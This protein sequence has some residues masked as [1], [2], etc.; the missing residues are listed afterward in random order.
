[1]DSLTWDIVKLLGVAAL[2]LTNAFFVAAEF[3]LVSVRRSRMEE[4]VAAGHTS[5]KTV[6]AA[7]RNLG[8]Y[9]AGAQ[10]G[11]TMASLGLGWL[12]EPALAHL[13]APLFSWTSP[14]LAETAAHTIA[15]ALAFVFITFLHVVFG[16]Q[17]PKVVAVQRGE[18]TSLWVMPLMRLTVALMR[19][20]VWAL[21]GV[22]NGVVRLLGLEPESELHGV[23]SVDELQILVRQ[24]RQAGVIDELEG[25]LVERAFRVPDLTARDVMVPRT[26]LIALDGRLPA[27]ELLN[28]VARSGH[29]RLPVY[30][31]TLD[32]I[33]GILHV[34]DVFCHLRQSNEPPDIRKLARAPLFVPETV[35][36]DDL[37][38]SFQQ[39]RSQVAV[40]TD[41]HGGVAGMVTLDDVVAEVFGE[42]QE[43]AD[44]RQPS[45]QEMPDGRLL[46]RGDVRLRELNDRFGWDLADEQADSIAGYVTN[47]LG[48]LA[49]PGDT[50]ETPQG[51]ITVEKMARLRI[52]LVAIL[53]KTRQQSAGGEQA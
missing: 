16:E 14:M 22:S 35:R 31:R 49:H 5:A 25:K 27:E 4:L 8:T 32:N 1:M 11:I 7:M 42:V 37:L 50:V 34:R 36:L 44:A 23:H 2:V 53:P 17:V 19:P 33:A 46:V 30:D 10:V 38:R 51:I 47:H 43:P 29:Q 40:V 48:R 41:E 52:L 26:D 15:V 13:L 9:I 21:N 3:A 28:R 18:A 39:Q 20:L 12:G 45:I 6:L 24:S